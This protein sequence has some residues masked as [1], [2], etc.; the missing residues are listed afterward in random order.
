MIPFQWAYSEILRICLE[1]TSG[2]L[3]NLNLWS[4]SVIYRYKDMI[5]AMR[6]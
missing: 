6:P 4:Q 1:I 5:L 2:G 3:I